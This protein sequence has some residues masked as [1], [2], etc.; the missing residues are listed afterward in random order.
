[1]KQGF[2]H[3]LLVALFGAFIATLAGHVEIQRDLRL[4]TET[5]LARNAAM[6]KILTS[7]EIEFRG[8]EAYLTGMVANREDLAALEEGLL[9][10]AVPA[11]FGRA[12]PA[13]T[14][15]HRDGVQVADSVH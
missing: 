9:T 11:R 14:R 13:V 10:A 1:M 5:V 15:V 2:F 6:A 12:I 7:V 8:Q 3:I 4:G